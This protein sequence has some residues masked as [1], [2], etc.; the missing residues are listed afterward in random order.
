MPFSHP[1]MLNFKELCS[2]YLSA[3]LPSSSPVYPAIAGLFAL[4]ATDTRWQDAATIGAKRGDYCFFESFTSSTQLKYDIVASK[5]MTGIHN[6]NKRNAPI[7]LSNDLGLIGAVL[8]G[9]VALVVM[10]VVGIWW[11]LKRI[12]QS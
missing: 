1:R 3:F 12:R 2:S 7:S 8:K 11:A 5:F 10:I 6:H 9:L 4:S